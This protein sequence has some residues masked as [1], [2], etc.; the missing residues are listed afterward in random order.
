[1]S[2]Y[3]QT[4]NDI[5]HDEKLKIDLSS[6]LQTKAMPNLYFLCEA[7]ALV[8]AATKLN[9]TLVQIPF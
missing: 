8:L 9:F 3:I 6:E 4:L 7:E 2:K 1:M 5:S